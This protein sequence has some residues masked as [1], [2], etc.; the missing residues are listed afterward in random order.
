MH[1]CYP[2]LPRQPPIPALQHLDSQHDSAFRGLSQM[3]HQGLNHFVGRKLP[4]IWSFVSARDSDALP[5]V[6][7]PF[8]E[9]DSQVIRLWAKKL[10]EWLVQYNGASRKA[11]PCWEELAM[12][13]ANTNIPACVHRALTL[14][15]SRYP[16]SPA[17]SSPQALR[18]FNLPSSTWL[19]P[20][21]CEHH[22]ERTA[23]APDVSAR[24]PATAAG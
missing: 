10:D 6:G 20:G 18:S 11:F 23:G 4:T 2:L 24:C 14:R 21:L 3:M 1:M 13:V 9:K 15:P 5:S 22:P 8:T 12:D 7:T 17:V 16:Y 19:R